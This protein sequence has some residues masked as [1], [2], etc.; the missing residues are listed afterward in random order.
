MGHTIPSARELRVVRGRRRGVHE[1]RR[2][3]GRY[4]TDRDDYWIDDEEWL[5]YWSLVRRPLPSLIFIL[6]FL[7]GYEFGVVQFGGNSPDTL[8]TGVDRWLRQGL[9]S[10]GLGLEFLLPLG[11]V[12][13][14]VT[15]MIASGPRTWKFQTTWL[16]GMAIESLALGAALIGVSRFVDRGLL[17][18]E[19]EPIWLAAGAGAQG[20]DTL[21]PLIGYLGAG[22]YEEAIFPPPNPTFR[23]MPF[24]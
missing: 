9:E 12:G 20:V 11:L 1:R 14:L 19:G 15:W 23:A 16:P 18:L 5:G 3:L 22:V 6:P 17:W 10:L 8:R 13:V 21:V 4:R 2:R 24:P 7:L